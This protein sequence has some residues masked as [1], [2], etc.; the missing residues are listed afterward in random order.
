MNINKEKQ[1]R[2]RQMSLIILTN[3]FFFVGRRGSHVRSKKLLETSVVK[4]C[5]FLR[6]LHPIQWNSNG[7]R[8]QK[9][10]HILEKFS[11]IVNDSYNQ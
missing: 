3:D 1:E 11:R 10:G 9:K 6:T 7:L 8:I 5:F 4:G 2:Y